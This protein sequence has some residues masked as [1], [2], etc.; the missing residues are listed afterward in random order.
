MVDVNKEMLKEIKE[1]LE[2]YSKLEELEPVIFD[3]FDINNYLVGSFSS[4]VN[5]NLATQLLSKYFKNE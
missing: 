1:V 2:H 3:M 5:P 4:I